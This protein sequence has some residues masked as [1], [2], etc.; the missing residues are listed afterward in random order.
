MRFPHKFGTLYGVG[1]RVGVVPNAD[2]PNEYLYEPFIMRSFTQKKSLI[3]SPN[4]N[5]EG[6]GESLSL[7]G[8]IRA[9]VS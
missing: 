2:T 7:T 1:G 5:K 3:L 4:L 6:L 9:T 8:L